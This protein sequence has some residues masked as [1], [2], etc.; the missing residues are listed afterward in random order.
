M[1]HC[2]H[3]QDP[4]AYTEAIGRAVHNLR[5]L[6]S[7]CDYVARERDVGARAQLQRLQAAMNGE[8]DRIEGV[9]AGK[10]PMA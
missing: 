10:P 5:A 9:R 3:V 8:L 1:R 7:I 2:S 6:S 4:A